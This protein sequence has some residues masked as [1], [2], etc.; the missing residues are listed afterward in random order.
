MDSV[1]ALLVIVRNMRE[2]TL[3]RNLCTVD[4]AK[5]ALQ[6]SDLVRYMKKD[7][8]ENLHSLGSAEYQRFAWRES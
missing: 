4:T 5:S 2:H 6:V 7:T 8:G 1:S 3:R